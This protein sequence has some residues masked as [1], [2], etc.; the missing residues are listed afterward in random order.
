VVGR[1]A[2]HS[3]YDDALATFEHE[4]VYDQRDA[5]GFIKLN[6]LRLRVLGRARR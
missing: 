4:D 3:L 1:Q 6:A 2:P 5:E